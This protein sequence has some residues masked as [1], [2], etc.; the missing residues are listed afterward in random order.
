M[1]Q[2]KLSGHPQNGIKPC[3]IN[4]HM[5]QNVLL[6]WLDANID[7]NSGD[8]RKTIN[9]LRRTVNKINTFTDT[10]QCLQ[11]L[12]DMADEKVCMI[13][14]G[15]LGQQFVPRVHHL[16]QMDS[17]FIF[18][19]NK[20]YHERWTKD[21]SKVKGVF[22]EIEPICGVLKQAAQQ[23]E[24]NAIPFS[25]M[26]GGDD[27]VENTGNRLDA[28]FMYTQIMKEIFLSINFQQQHIDEFLE[29]CR[30]ALSG[31]EKQLEYVEKLARKY[32]QHTP[33]WWYTCEC[34]LYPM[35]NRALRTMDV[36][37]IIKLGFFINDLHRQIE[38][39]HLKQCG[40]HGF[41]KPFTVYRGQGMIRDDFEKLLANKGGLLSFNSF[42]STS[43]D[44]STSFD[45]AYR[46]LAD[47]QLVGVLFVMSIDSARSNTPFASVTD[48]GYFQK[49]EEEVLFCMH[50]VF[51]IGEISSIDNN[52]SL[53][54]V[55]LNL[56]SDKDNNLC[57]LIDYIR[58]ETFPDSSGWYRLGSV[59]RKMG[60]AAK[61]QQVYEKLLKQE[62]N[63]S[64]RAVI[65]SQL[66]LMKYGQG[67]YQEAIVYYKKSI[68]IK[69][70]SG[71]KDQ[72]LAM[73]YNNIGAV[74]D[75]IGDHPKALSSHE[76]A[77]V[78][79]QQSLPDTHPSLA[80]SYNNI[81]LLYK[82]MGDY[83]KALFSY[84]KALTIQQQSLP[85]THPDLAASYNNIGNLY[86][87]MGD[88]PEA[89]VSYEKALAIQQQS[90]LPNHPDLA[91]TYN[92]M[93]L[94]HKN[95]GNYSKSRS[96]FE[97]AVDIAQRS[98]PAN[99]PELQKWKSNL[100][101]LEA[102]LL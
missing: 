11:F 67:E 23:C 13:I 21:W 89:L 24:Q 91:T 54:Q 52:A 99:H 16:S 38:Q 29:H 63:G 33:I 34:F 56:A 37:L 51:R 14:S 76:K 95:M 47:T 73:V 17:T 100:A 87:S 19:G 79:K 85:S 86:K 55:Q 93:G 96:C 94:V 62:I 84:E 43:K 18:C 102:T 71:H 97:R 61:A 3:R 65:Y 68:K 44:R 90:L 66:G 30:E 40:S 39:L 59:L 64:G 32:R 101:G 8:C 2:G 31:N 50:T 53:V 25:I 35:L 46:A 12:E 69:E 45:F 60:E 74:Y 83:P 7:E 48:I 9:H 92:N 49:Q 58:K 57:Q 22:T 70:R 10:E 88:Y 82:N 20:K 42:L 27:V 15:S 1:G 41:N 28:S 6:V 78:I 72:N 80:M 5:V 81:G 77:L 75:S 26:S 98:L 4:V 36:D